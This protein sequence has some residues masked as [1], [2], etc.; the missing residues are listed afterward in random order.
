LIVIP[1]RLQ[2][3]GDYR[4]ERFFG[5]RPDSAIPGF[6]IATQPFG[7][8]LDNL[9]DLHSDVG[10]R[11]DAALERA[12]RKING[13]F[14]GHSDQSGFGGEGSASAVRSRYLSDGWFWAEN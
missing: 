6:E 2:G 14:R 1:C 12:R 5:A 8:A 13:S 7:C 9:R 11:H 3:G 4:R 10:G